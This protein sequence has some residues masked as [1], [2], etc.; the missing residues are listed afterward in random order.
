MRMTVTRYIAA[1]AM[2]RSLK[3]SPGYTTLE[4]HI[5]RSRRMSDPSLRCS[6]D[7]SI[8]ICSLIP[9]RSLTQTK[10][11]PNTTRPMVNWFLVDAEEICKRM[12][13]YISHAEENNTNSLC[14]L[15][16]LL[17]YHDVCSD[18]PDQF[19]AGGRSVTD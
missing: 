1:R 19:R 13:V 18:L 17:C 2:I 3:R 11:R 5:T 9:M 8:C 15:E 14:P 16:S 10:P 4:E 6:V 12:D 7:L